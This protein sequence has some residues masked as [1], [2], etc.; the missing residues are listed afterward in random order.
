MKELKQSTRKILVL[1]LALSL[2]MA[3]F[4][5]PGLADEIAADRLEA[6]PDEVHVLS[7]DNSSAYESGESNRTI[8][9]IPPSELSG[10]GEQGESR[11]A[12]ELSDKSES[13]ASGAAESLPGGDIFSE[14]APDR[15]KRN[16]VEP[17]EEASGGGAPGE[18]ASGG[19]APG[20]G[21]PGEAEPE[22]GEP[23][24]E[25]PGDAEPEEG[26]PGEGE[27]GAGE[28]GDSEFGEGESG[29]TPPEEE[30]PVEEEGY[31]EYQDLMPLDGDIPGELVVDKVAVPGANSSEVDNIWE[32]DITLTLRGLDFLTASDIVLVIDTSSSMGSGENS[33]M[34]YAKNAALLFVRELLK[35]DDGIRIALIDYNTAA[36][37]RNGLT[38]NL[39]ELE[40]AINSL[41]ALGTTN[42]QDGLAQAQ[43]LLNTSTANN[44]YIVLL[45]DG[46]PTYSYP[47]T[48]V[49]NVS[50]SAC[51][52]DNPVWNVTAANV[53]TTDFTMLFNETDMVGD[54]TN[55]D[56]SYTGLDAGKGA[57]VNC[58]ENHNHPFPPNH[59]IPTIYQAKT[60]KSQNID[61]YSIAVASGAVGEMVLQQCASGVDG[62]DYAYAIAN[63]TPAELDKLDSIFSEISGKIL[64]AARSAV[65]TDPIGEMFN[66]VSGIST[67]KGTA[68]YNASPAPGTITWDIGDVRQIDDVITMRYTVRIDT[69]I[70]DPET[71]YPTNKTTYVDYIDV[72][73]DNVRKLFPIP[74]VGYPQVGSITKMIYIVDEF[75]RPLDAQGQPAASRDLIDIVEMERVL[76]PTPVSADP[77]VFHY[78]TYT[79]TADLYRTINGGSYQFVQGTALNMGD[80][81]PTSVTVSVTNQSARVYYAYQLYFSLKI[82]AEASL[83]TNISTK[84]E[85]WQREITPYRLDYQYISSGY[86]SVTATTP[87]QLALKD[88]FINPKN[89]NLD[90]KHAKFNDLV[91]KNA[92]HFTFA[93][94]PVA[95]LAAGGVDLVLVVGNKIDEIGTGKAFI[96]ADGKLELEFDDLNSYKFGAVAFTKLLEPKNGNIHSEKVFSHNN[97]AVL[98]LPPADAGGFIYL[99]V[100]FDSLEL[101][102]GYEEGISEWEETI[103]HKVGER[104]EDTTTGPDPLYVSVAVYLCD[105]L[106][107]DC[108]TCPPIYNF[109]NLPPGTYKVVFTVY[110][111]DGTVREEAAELVVIVTGVDTVVNFSRDY[112]DDIEVGG[113]REYVVPDIVNPLVVVVKVVTKK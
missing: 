26:E 50:I 40:G 111:D 13:E 61:I 28:P 37:V 21:S 87:S 39:A 17:G 7:V 94:L 15:D 100:H 101:D 79:V 24:K 78:G 48:A 23:G 62:A 42:I 82:N 33:K 84:I 3:N 14:E 6:Y 77:Y 41:N 104:F 32:W 109:T 12:E 106:D 64:Y 72:Y 59:G 63:S 108:S 85:I 67:S 65:V 5:A 86:S 9:L 80:V 76:N 25:E 4:I 43:K 83:T 47:C 49:T 74:Q 103:E 105:D 51:I 71:M 66:L 52:E 70:A 30:T 57:L 2:I 93:K 53:N 95:E 113:P 31:L 27:H 75:G 10:S 29:E 81:S 97:V 107:C 45:S 99:Y 46:D 38:T 69:S 92:N 36:T 98:D 54:G 11:A 58:P 34:T 73:G 90:S 44:K 19:G 22:E 16:G 18:E 96:N 1:M 20:E 88:L 89:G 112:V 91:V 8:E 55:Y 56:I 102:L 60:A 110:N 35:G 68:T